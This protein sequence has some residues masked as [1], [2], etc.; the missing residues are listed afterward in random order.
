MGLEETQ[1]W[2]EGRTFEG[3]PKSFRV[4][5]LPPEN[6]LREASRPGTEVSKVE[7]L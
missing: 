4:P 2:G 3:E 6:V 1:G 5:L 7:Y